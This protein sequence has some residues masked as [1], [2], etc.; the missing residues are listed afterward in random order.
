M[1]G[2]EGQRTSR[3]QA[4]VVKIENDSKIA[5]ETQTAATETCQLFNHVRLAL[6]GGNASPCRTGLLGRDL[7]NG[8]IQESRYQTLMIQFKLIMWQSVTQ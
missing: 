7:I 6:K 2:L 4:P 8:T 1:I 5:V 3:I